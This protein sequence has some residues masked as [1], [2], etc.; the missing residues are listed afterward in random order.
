[1]C[2]V[3]AHRGP[4]D[5]GIYTGE[6]IGLGHRRLSILD[7]ESGHQPMTNEDKTVWIVFN[8]E[9][10]NYLTIKEELVKKGHRFRTRCDTEVIIHAYEEY[11]EDCLNRFEGMFA[12]AIWDEKQQTLFLARDRIGIKPLYYSLWNGEIIFASEIKAILQQKQIPRDIHID[13]M[14]HFFCF[15]YSSTERTMLKHVRKL[16]PGHWLICNSRGV[17]MRQYWDLHFEQEKRKDESVYLEDLQRILDESIKKRLQSD[18]PLGAFLSGGLDSS[19]IVAEMVRLGVHPIQ[20]F[21]V[22]FDEEGFSELPHARRVARYLNTEH[23]EITITAGDYEAFFPGFVW[24]QD[25]PMSDPATIALYYLS[26]LARKSVTVVLTGEGSDEIFAGYERYL[27]EK[28]IKMTHALPPVVRHKILVPI[29]AKMQK[30]RRFRK[31]GLC[32]TS[33]GFDERF[34]ALR[35]AFPA[36]VRKNLYVKDLRQRIDR[37]KTV[38]Q[39]LSYLHRFQQQDDLSTMLYADTKLWLPEDM[40]MKKDKMG[41]AASIEARVPFLDHH[42]VEFAARLPA[43]M[44]IKGLQGKYI[45]RKLMSGRLPQ[46][47]VKRK[48]QGFPVPLNDWIRKDLKPM[49]IDLLDS[50]KIRNRG[51]LNK[52]FINRLLAEHLNHKGN[53]AHMLFT[54]MCFEMW[55]RIFIDGDTPKNI[56]A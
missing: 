44:K 32:L 50:P 16:P 53:H 49:T 31:I 47:I 27:G 3:L 46:S 35:S 2:R 21:S 39:V 38:D 43:D 1:M 42:L 40:L 6:H 14:D 12:F 26:K 11:A 5:E 4:D 28:I 20:T 54:L 24:H 8:G 41:M 45:L 51:I 29:A 48:K 9:I 36:A 56:G 25:E 10:Y 19:A 34:V 15:G 52:S 17:S 23:H 13:T 18:V 30:N 22:G 33:K 37:T 55:C 7:L